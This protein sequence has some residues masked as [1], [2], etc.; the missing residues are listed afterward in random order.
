M[1]AGREIDVLV[2]EHVMG[3]HVERIKPDWYP[4]EVTLFFRPG[5][6]LVE[7]SY[8]ENACNAMMHRNGKDDSDG[9]ASPLPFYS[10]EIE[11]AWEVVEKLAA[12]GWNVAVETMANTSEAPYTAVSFWRGDD[13]DTA[14]AMATDG[15]N[16]ASLA[17]CLAALKALNVEVP[18]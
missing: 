12:N 13:W 17:I 14:E 16:T 6:P 7:Y 5:N 11:H 18:E 8:D 2:A 10:E 4:H 3:F 15:A 9:T 1:K